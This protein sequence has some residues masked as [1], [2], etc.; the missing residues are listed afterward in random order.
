MIERILTESRSLRLFVCC[1]HG[2]EKKKLHK[3]TTI[4]TA[5]ESQHVNEMYQRIIKRKIII[6]FLVFLRPGFCGTL[7]P[8]KLPSE[9]LLL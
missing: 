5:V 8:Q 7:V 2:W 4:V 1:T 6:I 3:K 9:S